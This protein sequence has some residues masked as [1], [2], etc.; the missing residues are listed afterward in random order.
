MKIVR[1]FLASSSSLF[2]EREAVELFVSRRNDKLIE[3]EIYIELTIWDKY[4]KSFDIDRKQD[5][6]NRLIETSDLFI[7][8]AHGRVGNF[9]LEE[10]RYAVQR[11]RS[12]QK[13]RRIIVYFNNAPLRPSDMGEE[14][15]S[16]V[17]LRKEL[18][19]LEQIWAEYDQIA[20]L[21]LQIQ[22]E[23]DS[24][25]SEEEI[26]TKFGRGRVILSAH[27]ILDITDRDGRQVLCERRSHFRA[28][29][30]LQTFEDSL[31]VDGHIETNSI[32]TEPDIVKRVYKE[33][34]RVEIRSEFPSPISVGQ[35]VL[36]T[37]NCVL[38]DTFVNS[39]E[40]WIEDQVTSCRL[41]KVTIIFPMNRPPRSFRST[42][43]REWYTELPCAQPTV[44]SRRERQVINF[45]EMNKRPGDRF[46]L[47][48]DW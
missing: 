3:R 14:F 9:T 10:F 36:R 27:T 21:L 40:Y 41:V 35:E 39:S 12:G 38:T 46:R 25:L 44:Q 16:I 28:I 30:E 23:I 5:F 42:L 19:S 6:F 2:K 31:Q 22:R 20:D 48:W 7:V 37:L 34:G 47:M 43:L 11:F 32:N 18:H 4:S 29:S 17:S 15:Q 45:Q 8:I 13:P 33:D 1:L 26:E 24:Y